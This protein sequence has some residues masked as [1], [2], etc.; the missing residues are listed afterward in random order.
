MPKGKPWTREEERTLTHL[1]KKRK[2][3]SVIAK[4]L[5]KT[6]NAVFLKIRRLGLQV[7]EESETNQLSSSS[8]RLPNELPSIDNVM[9]RLTLALEELEQQ[10]P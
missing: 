2:D 7:E 1:V 6:E 10:G 3:I 9:K 8:R 5:G 4:A